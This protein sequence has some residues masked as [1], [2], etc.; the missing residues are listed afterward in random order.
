MMFI[1]PKGA[2]IAGTN[3]SKFWVFNLCLKLNE[4][5][6]RFAFW[7]RGQFAFWMVFCYLIFGD[8]FPL[9][10]SIFLTI[11]FSYMQHTWTVWTEPGLKRQWKNNWFTYFWALRLTWALALLTCSADI[12]TVH[13][14]LFSL[15][16]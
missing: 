15:S 12:I 9:K 5:G 7:S 4:T 16:K 10:Q 13:N 2:V 1:V 11:W 8:F 14:S 3:L 6:G